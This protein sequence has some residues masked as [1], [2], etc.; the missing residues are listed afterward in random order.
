MENE[1]VYAAIALLLSAAVLILTI[2]HVR[3]HERHRI[4]RHDY[5]RLKKTK[6]ITAIEAGDGPGRRRIEYGGA[7][8]SM[9][10]AGDD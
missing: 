8:E 6:R 1:L 7:D 10:P 9:P 4:L 2:A 3:L 5:C